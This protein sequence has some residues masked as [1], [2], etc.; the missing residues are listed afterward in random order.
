[1]NFDLSDEQQII[2]DLAAQIFAGQATTERVKAVE[3]ADGFDRE[4]WSALA[5]ANLLGLCLPERDGGSA[6]GM[7]ELA[8]LAE[9]QG[10]WVAP[11]PVIPTLA[12]AMTVAAHGSD[13]QRSQLLPGVIDGSLVLTSALAESGANDVASPTTRATT[14]ADGYRLIGYR[15]AVPY[16]QHAARIVVPTR[17]DNGE[18]AL[19]VIDPAADGVIVQVAD[20]TDR[21]AL[22]HVTID[23]EV[24]TASRFGDANALVQLHQQFTVGWCA[25]HLGVAEG[26]LA[27]ARCGC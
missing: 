27:V 6:M 26:S 17:L 13:E 24:P 11:V 10:R 21:Q 16:A 7:V 19:F 14:T 1:M 22:A 23:T 15:P 9:Q 20:T 3:A 18:V 4:L 25:V 5:D 2:H 12:T 8:L